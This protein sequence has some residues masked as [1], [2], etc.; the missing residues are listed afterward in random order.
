MDNS[1]FMD[2]VEIGLTDN[3]HIAD[4]MG[5]ERLDAEEE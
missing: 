3:G 4:G 5:V 1:L 2:G